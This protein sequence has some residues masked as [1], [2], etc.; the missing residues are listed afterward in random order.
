M[1]IISEYEFRQEDGPGAMGCVDSFL[2]TV[3]CK[4]GLKHGAGF[5]KEKLRFRHHGVME[6]RE[7]K[8]KCLNDTGLTNPRE[9]WKLRIGID[10]EQMVKDFE[11]QREGPGF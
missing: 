8:W 6:Q 7:D 2:A 5:R 10:W 11:G 3:Q 4:L 9:L 1:Q